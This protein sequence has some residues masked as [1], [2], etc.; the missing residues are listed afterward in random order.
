MEF[1]FI[2][3]KQMYKQSTRRSLAITVLRIINKK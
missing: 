3:G 2:L 1:D